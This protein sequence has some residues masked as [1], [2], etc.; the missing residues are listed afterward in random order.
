MVPYSGKFSN[1][2]NFCIIRKHAACAKIKTCENLFSKHPIV[3]VV[4]VH[5]LAVCLGNFKNLNFEI[6]F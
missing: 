3:D 5:A 6:L 4:R 1:G 2:A